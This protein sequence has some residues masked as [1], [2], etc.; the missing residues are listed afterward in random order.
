MSLTMDLRHVRDTKPVMQKKCYI[1]EGF[2][3]ICNYDEIFDQNAYS[4]MLQIQGSITESSF[5]IHK[6]NLR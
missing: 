2:S 5:Y 3:S 6:Q 4:N 1:Y